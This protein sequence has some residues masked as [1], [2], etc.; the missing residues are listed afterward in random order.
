MNSKLKDSNMDE[1]FKAIL[2]LENIDECYAFFDDLCTVIELK[3]IS[4]RMQVA[5]MLVSKNVYSDIVQTT[6][7]STATISRVN[8]TL[9]YGSDGYALVFKRLKELEEAENKE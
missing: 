4:Q 7:A 9:N 3:A 2:T 6:G 8:R 5:K 1:L